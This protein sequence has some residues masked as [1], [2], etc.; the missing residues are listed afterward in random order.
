MQGMDLND[1]VFLC[2]AEF[3]AMLIYHHGKISLAL[4]INTVPSQINIFF[5]IYEH[6]IACHF[7]NN[8]GRHH[9]QKYI[10]FMIE[11]NLICP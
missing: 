2:V 10:A 4:L 5:Y 9:P 8:T 1:S 11:L 3:V 7:H 6:T